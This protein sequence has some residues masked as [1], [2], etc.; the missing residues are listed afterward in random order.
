MIDPT[1]AECDSTCLWTYERLME[2]TE[3]YCKLIVFP[4]PIELGG[5]ILS[6][7]WHMSE[8]AVEDMDRFLWL[9]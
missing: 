1:P 2:R 5:L 3:P 7:G 9:M 4:A 6:G 8:L